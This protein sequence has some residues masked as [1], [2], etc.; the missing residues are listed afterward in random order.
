VLG[1]NTLEELALAMIR[2]DASHF[3]VCSR[4]PGGGVQTALT[5]AGKRFIAVLMS[6]ASRCAILPFGPVTTSSVQLGRL[7]PV[8]PRC[9]AI[10][11]FPERSY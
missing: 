3:L 10:P 9:W 5:Q 11:L 6:R 4:Q 1:L 7:H 8:A 2:K